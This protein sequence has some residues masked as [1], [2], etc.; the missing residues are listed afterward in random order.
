MTPQLKES[1]WVM[2]GTRPLLLF[3]CIQ[4][5]SVALCLSH[6]QTPTL[7]R[8]FPKLIYHGPPHP[9]KASCC[10]KYNKPK[11]Q[12]N[13]IPWWVM[14]TWYL[15]QEL[16]IEEPT[17]SFCTAL[18]GFKCSQVQ[19]SPLC[20]HYLYVLRR[21]PSEE[22]PPTSV[23]LFPQLSEVLVYPQIIQCQRRLS[24]LCY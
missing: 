13:W 1:D 14:K 2:L 22:H 6:H 19:V 9:T 7:W 16:A 15:K 24:L 20:S 8:S 23:L 12:E 10:L 21:K 5:P 11:V 3:F 18:F 4:Q 17:I